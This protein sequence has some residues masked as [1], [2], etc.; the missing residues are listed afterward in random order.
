MK[1]L[2]LGYRVAGTKVDDKPD[3][4]DH[5]G[6]VQNNLVVFSFDG[7]YAEIA[8]SIITNKKLKCDLAKLNDTL[9]VILVKPKTFEWIDEGHNTSGLLNKLS[10]ELPLKVTETKII[11]CLVNGERVEDEIEE[12][13]EL[14]FIQTYDELDDVPVYLLPLTKSKLY[15]TDEGTNS[16]TEMHKHIATLQRSGYKTSQIAEILNTINDH[17][18]VNKIPEDILRNMTS[19]ESFCEEDF[20]GE[21]GKFLHHVFGDYLLA[22]C[23]VMLI[24]EQLNIYTRDKVYKADTIEIE[25]VM[26]DKIPALKDSQ[27]KEVYKYMVL[28]CKRR[29]CYSPAN[30]IGLKDEIL[31][32]ETM[33]RLP[34]SPDHVIANKI[35][36]NYDPTAYSAVV[37]KVLDNVSCN[38]K[39]MRALL[40]E[41]IGYTLYRDNEM[42]TSFFLTGY[43][44]NGKSK[45]LDMIKTLLGKKN[46]VSLE[47][48]DLEDKYL[49]AQLHGK[50]A[51]I[52]DDISAK[53]F[54][55]SSI[56]KKLVTGESFPAQHKYG[57]P[58]EL[59]SYATLLFCANEMP[60]VNDRTDGFSRRLAIV[61]FDAKF[62]KSD[63][64]FDPFLKHKLATDEAMNYLLKLAIEGLLRV[65]KNAGFTQVERCDVEKQKFMQDNNPILCWLETEPDIINR[66][67]TSVYQ[68]YKMWCDDNGVKPMKLINVSRELATHLNL[69]TQPKKSKDGISYR[70]YVEK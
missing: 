57:Q 22:N 32:V 61:P 35:E 64:D 8:Q 54:E 33:E 21:R 60:A 2:Y 67:T 42:Q 56:Y 63:K 25:R 16:N 68:V 47:L 58:F 62:S 45:Y 48:K 50:L 40:E 14:K 28:Q 41:I 44:G 30:L 29:G 53:F 31:N 1:D 34:Y 37:D 66:N 15:F 11:E 43:G 5:T 19:E 69:K 3:V 10:N 27:R 52:G 65:L 17:V 23:D 36:Y 13:T 38:D 55:N 24:D 20:F 49:P 18:L 70:I 51:N 59:D 26:L 39:K 4:G 7:V 46:F 6:I 9:Y 12:E